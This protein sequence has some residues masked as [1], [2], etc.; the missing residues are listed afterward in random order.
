MYKSKSRRKHFGIDMFPMFNLLFIALAFLIL[1]GRPA[2]RYPLA[3]NLPTGSYFN[4]AD[5]DGY[6]TTILIGQNKLMLKLDVADIREVALKQI[7]KGHGT[8]FTQAEATKF[9]ETDVIGT[10]LTTIKKYISGYYNATDYYN[11]PGLTTDELAEWIKISRKVTFEKYGRWSHIF[12]MADADTPYP[13]I[14]NVIAMLGQQKINKF[15]I[16][17][18]Y[19]KQI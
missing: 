4:T 15:S 7:G 3:I 2:I 8:E 18:S 10:P 19:K 12:I 11:Q 9:C 17:Y 14:K 5:P 6:A 13:N 16:I 1:C